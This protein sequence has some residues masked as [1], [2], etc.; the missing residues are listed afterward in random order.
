MRK[1]VLTTTILTM[2]AAY[3]AATGILESQSG[4]LVL[5]PEDGDVVVQ[6]AELYLSDRNMEHALVQ[7]GGYYRNGWPSNIILERNDGLVAAT[8]RFAVTT[9]EGTDQGSIDNMFDPYYN[10]EARWRNSK[11]TYPLTI[12]VDLNGKR[13]FVSGALLGFGWRDAYADS[14]YVEIYED[15]NNDGA[16]QWTNVWDV[17]GNSDNV[18]GK[19]WGPKWRVSKM[20]LVVRSANNNLGWLRIARFMMVQQHSGYEMGHSLPV[21]GGTLYGPVVPYTGNTVDLGSDAQPYR[22]VYAYNFVDKTPAFDTKKYRKTALDAIRQQKF[23]KEDGI[24]AIDHD[25]LPEFVRTEMLATTTTGETRMI[26]G[27]CVNCEVTLQTQAIQELEAKV[28]E[29]EAKVDGGNS[30]RIKWLNWR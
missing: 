14:F 24:L 16:Y 26:Q 30:K 29:L 10:S 11:T 4:S 1:I 13:D 9:S 3:A 21:H 25:S 15:G 6:D 18:V 12:E 7:L 17:T 28:R 19:F 20:R 22:S 23:K 2:V 8:K 5:K 27:R